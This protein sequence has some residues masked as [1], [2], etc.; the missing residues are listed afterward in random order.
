MGEGLAGCSRIVGV[1]LTTG[2]PIPP[3]G[4]RRVTVRYA[5][6]YGSAP[7]RLAP[8]LLLYA[9]YVKTGT[10]YRTREVR[11]GS[12]AVT[13]KSIRECRASRSSAPAGGGSGGAAVPGP[14]TAMYTPEGHSPGTVKSWPGQR[15][16]SSWRPGGAYLPGPPVLPMR[17]GRAPQR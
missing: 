16:S 7:Y 13:T 3:P 8:P 17:R 5:S 9:W 11:A 15:Q 2:P 12:R 1:R 6:S 10:L 14:S 4:R